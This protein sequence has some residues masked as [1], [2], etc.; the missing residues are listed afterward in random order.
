MEYACSA[1][2]LLKGDPY[3][4]SENND[5]LRGGEIVIPKGKTAK[6]FENL[7]YHYKWHIIIISFFVTVFAICFVQCA[8]TPRPDV[9]FTYAGGYAFNGE[10][11]A[12]INQ[13]FS[14]LVSDGDEEK[15][16]VAINPYTIYTEDELYKMYFED[17]M[18]PEQNSAATSAYNSAKVAGF[19]V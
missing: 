5:K 18:D 15:T 17:G 7:W 16:A 13:L 12:P 10:E 3:T 1:F 14:N 8:T 11:K 4:M 9:L 2:L 19:C 6:F